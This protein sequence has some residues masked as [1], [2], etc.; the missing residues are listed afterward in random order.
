MKTCL[1]FAL[2]LS[3][4]LL[5][6]AL[7]FAQDGAAPD[8][9]KARVQSVETWARKMEGA[10]RNNRPKDVEGFL[11]LD[12]I[13]AATI[14]GIEVDDKA[15]LRGFRSGLKS[16]LGTVS[17]TLWQQWTANQP[18]FKQVVVVAGEPAAR[19]RFCGENGISILDLRLNRDGDTW[20]VC[21]VYN[22]AFG[23]GMVDNMRSAAVLMLKN[24]DSSVIARLFGAS[25]VSRKDNTRI[26]D[27]TRKIRQGDFR[28]AVAVHAKLSDTMKQTSMVTALHVQ[29]LSMIDGETDAYVAALEDAAKRFPAPQFRL[30]LVDAHFLKG[31]WDEGL[32]C[33]DECM[34]AVGRDAALLTLRAMLNFAAKRTAAAVADL[35]EAMAL[36]PDCEYMLS[37]GLDVWIAAEDWKAVA[38]AITRLEKTGEYDFK[39]AISGEEWGGFHKSPES[40]PWR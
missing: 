25:K 33:L 17:N 18:T 22:H 8:S 14:E 7:V 9:L 13:I 11:D 3:S 12:A 16:S 5:L 26:A 6:P 10:L 38:K 24:L 29:A 31:Q 30:T 4:L 20:R 36:E 23:L 40:K 28:G 34:K 39:G 37:S 32:A 1:A 2:R 21:D 27:M 15:V 35:N 19:F